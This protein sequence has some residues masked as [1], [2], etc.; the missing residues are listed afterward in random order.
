VRKN[1]DTTREQKRE[2]ERADKEAERK[3]KER[4]KELEAIAKLP[5]LAHEL[6]LAELARRS[7]EDLDFLRDE[8]GLLRSGGHRH[9]A[10]RAMGPAGRYACTPDR[11]DGAAEAH[12]TIAIYWASIPPSAATLRR[13]HRSKET[14]SL[15]FAFP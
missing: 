5:C 15:R 14:S 2:L 13:I 12:A 3:R 8:C 7:G 10:Y 9:Q 6:R 11:V 4:E 1:L